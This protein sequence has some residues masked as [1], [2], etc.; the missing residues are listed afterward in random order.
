MNKDKNPKTRIRKAVPAKRISNII[1]P[2]EMSSLEW[3][4]TLRRQQAQK[5]DFAIRE[6]D[7]V[8]APGE[9]TV[10]NAKTRNEY[11]VS[12][13]GEGHPLNSCSCMDFR[14]SRIG[15][16]KHLEAV[17]AWIPA[18]KGR[19]VHKPEEGLTRIYMDYS[20]LRG[21]CLQYGM[22]RSWESLS[23]VTMMQW[24]GLLYRWM[25][26]TAICGWMMFLHLPHGGRM[27]FPRA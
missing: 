22:P 2:G 6:A 9:Y 10:G 8:R 1:K 15:S 16:C 24:N 4:L 26:Q 3:Q 18:A 20:S 7:P 23:A 21:F 19:C 12:F 13:Y 11:R 27:C 17:A 5:E 14:T 25:R